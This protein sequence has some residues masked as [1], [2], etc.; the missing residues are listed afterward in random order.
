MNL[1]TILIWITIAII[2][3]IAIIGVRLH[4]RGN[5]LAHEEGSILPSTENIDKVLA[6]GKE[7]I[8]MKNNAPQ[9][10]VPRSLSPNIPKKEHNLN[11]FRTSTQTTNRND[12]F[13]VPEVANSDIAKYEYQSQ[14]QVLVNYDNT[15]EKFQ[16]PIKQNQMDIMT[17]SNKDTSELKD[18]FTIDELIKESKR[19]DSKREK[20]SQTIKKEEDDTE[21]NELK[22]SIKNKTQEP[23]IEEV[24]AEDKTETISDL[25]KDTSESQEDET[26]SVVSQKPVE[27]V[28]IEEKEEISEVILTPEKTEEISEPA[29]KTPSKVDEEKDYK[30][31]ASIDDAN[32]FGEEKEPD[33]MDLDYRK[34]IDRVKNRIAS[35]RLFKDVK[36]KFVAES[37]EDSEDKIQEEFIR[38]VNEYDEYEPII[39]ETHADYE[40]SY[41]EYHDQQ[42]RQANTR[43][44]FNLAKNSPEPELARPKLSEIKDKPARDNIKI[45]INNEEVVL[46]KGD[47][48]IFNHDGETY[49]SQVYAINGDDISVRYRRKDIKIKASDVKKIY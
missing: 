42:L 43:R 14:N 40:A 48:I 33:N 3:A 39:N 12:D 18:L 35:S 37:E 30:M 34:D 16:E 49:S 20:E 41:E 5:E 10:N 24:I 17:Q 26:P 22:E 11:L 36:G 2:A 19:K 15:V 8:N 32:I 28:E 1:I 9:R 21:L 31:G 25:I 29:L 23:L 44:V 4:Y 46:K 6:I 7:K 45:D 27:E 38:N 47:E 13:I